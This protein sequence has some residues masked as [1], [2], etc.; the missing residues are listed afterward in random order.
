MAILEQLAEVIGCKITE[1]FDEPDDENIPLLKSG[2]KRKNS[3]LIK[4]L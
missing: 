3:R 2:G 4:R 1:F